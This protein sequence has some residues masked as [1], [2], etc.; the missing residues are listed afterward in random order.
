MER[1]SDVSSS[2]C[3]SRVRCVRI[4][5]SCL[6]VLSQRFW[7]GGLLRSLGRQKSCVTAFADNLRVPYALGGRVINPG[8]LAGGLTLAKALR[9]GAVDEGI[10]EVGVA[11]R[12]RG[13]WH[14]GQPR[15]WRRCRGSTVPPANGEGL[16]RFQFPLC[17]AAAGLTRKLERTPRAVASD[18]L[19]GA[20]EETKVRL[21]A[22]P[23]AAGP[24][25]MEVRSSFRPDP[26]LADVNTAQ[27]QV[28]GGGGG[29]VGRLEP[30][31][32]PSVGSV[33]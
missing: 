22:R 23:R 17:A 5:A 18:L 26:H 14:G 1:D 6:K 9:E 27:H 24:R 11:G 28:P 33:L 15:R 13:C 7:G 25:W 10:C 8:L 29:I 31:R 4:H 3:A 16:W 20:V 30:G 32:P 12:R 19:T 21:E 2:S